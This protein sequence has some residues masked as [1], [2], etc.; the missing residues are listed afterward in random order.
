MFDLHQILVKVNDGVYAA[1]KSYMKQKRYRAKNLTFQVT[2]SEDAKFSLWRLKR[3]L[4]AKD[5]NATLIELDN[6]IKQRT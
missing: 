3:K 6:I 4:N 2:L 5:Y 1:L